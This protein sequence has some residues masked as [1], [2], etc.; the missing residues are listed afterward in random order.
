M[1]AGIALAD[2][3]AAEALRLFGSSRISVD[4]RLAQRLLDWLLGTWNEENTSLPDIYQR[5]LNAML[6]SAL[7]VENRR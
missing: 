2:H 6:A 1:E 4:L 5:G 3:Y 7:V